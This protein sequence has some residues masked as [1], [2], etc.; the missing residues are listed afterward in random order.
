VVADHRPRHFRNSRHQQPIRD[1]IA[2]SC[3][4]TQERHP[5]QIRASR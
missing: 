5:P 1:T 3:R 4:R 2:Y